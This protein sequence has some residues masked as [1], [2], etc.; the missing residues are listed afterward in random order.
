MPLVAAP[1]WTCFQVSRLVARFA[2]SGE[3]SESDP[4]PYLPPRLLVAVVLNYRIEKRTKS[5]CLFDHVDV[6]GK[7]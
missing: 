3:K 7:G 6:V 1:S 5:S 2:A 4:T